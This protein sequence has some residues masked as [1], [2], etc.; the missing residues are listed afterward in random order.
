MVEDGGHNANNCPYR[1]RRS[2][3]RLAAQ[4]GLP[5]I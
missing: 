4:L 5:R 3:G 1:Y 2:A